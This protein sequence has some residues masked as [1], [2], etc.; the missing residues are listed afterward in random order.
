[1]FFSFP[2]PVLSNMSRGLVMVYIFSDFLDYLPESLFLFLGSLF[3][4]DD[5]SLSTLRNPIAE[6]ESIFNPFSLF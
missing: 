1:M 6:Q 5:L 3:S 2:L 4:D